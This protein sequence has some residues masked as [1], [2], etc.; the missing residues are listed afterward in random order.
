[1]KKINIKLTQEHQRKV[2]MSM[3]HW[4]YT[5]L[6]MPN[7]SCHNTWSFEFLLILDQEFILHFDV[8]LSTSLP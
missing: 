2:I 8:N 7:T 1:M 6:T 3:E 5:T 4:C